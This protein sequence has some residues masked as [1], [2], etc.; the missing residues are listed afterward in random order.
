M[1]PRRDP[2]PDCSFLVEIDGLI[3]GGFSE[4]GGLEA[5]VE[6]FE[7][8][9]G[10]LNGYAHQ[11]A[12]PARYPSRLVLRRGVVDD[13]VLW[14]WY[15]ETARGRIRRRSG[16]VVLR[17]AEGGEARRWSFFDALPARWVGPRLNAAQASVAIEALELVHHGLLAESS[18]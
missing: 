10:G 6:I 11:L 17:D 5:E 16:A 15:E 12:G 7:V 18:R 14:D 1:R 13:P 8:R 9:E 2:L 4:V 3:V